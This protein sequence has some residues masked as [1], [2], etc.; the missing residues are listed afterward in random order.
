[1]NEK[2]VFEY[3]TSEENAWKTTRIPLTG[4]KDWNMSEHIE[5]CTNVANAWFHSGKNDGTRPYD[6]IVTPII[7]VAFRTEGFDVKDIVPYVDD[8][9]ESYKSFIIKKLHPQW[10]RRMELDTLIDD[11]VETSVIY[12]LVLMKDVN[13]VRPEVVDLKTIA[14][15]DQ[16][17]VLAGPICLKHQYT[18]AEMVSFKGK[19]DDDKINQAIIQSSEEKTVSTANDQV[20]KTPSKYITVYELRGMMP[21]YWLKEDGEMHDYVNQMHLVC[22]YH[23]ATG[24]KQGITLYKGEDKPLT[25]TFK[26]LKIDRIRSKGRACGRS[27]V[28][29]L[30]E[31]Q[32]WNNYAGIKLKKMLDSAV[33]LVITDSDELAN[34]KLT[35]LKDNTILK[36]NKGDTT[37]RLDGQLQNLPAFQNY[38][39]KQE[40]SARN[41]GS[42]S[43]L[44]LG[45]TPA[46]GTPL[47]TTEIVHTEGVGIHEYRQGKIATFFADVL[48]RD[49]ILGYLVKE[50]NTGV[51]FSE[52]LSLDEMQE[53]ASAIGRNVVE[54]KIKRVILETGKIPT[55]QDREMMTQVFTDEFMKG[56]NRKFFETIKGELK[57]IPVSVMINIKGKQ[58]R[59]AQNADKITNIIRE[60]VRNPQMTQVPGIGKALNELLEESGMSPIDW[61]QITKVQP[62]Q[63]VQ[64]GTFNPKPQAE[65]QEQP[66]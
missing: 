51:K 64:G 39:I 40:N 47:G 48:Y 8:V 50:I 33:N 42:A 45:N 13:S 21:E 17:D 24:N 34:Q 60:V 19:W 3:I 22:Y 58:R 41:I 36:Q 20:A 59:M 32:V 1:M 2:T 31:P 30:F 63:P 15:C 55:D 12:D 37:M 66:A 25:D 27:I 6:D 44:A 62:A 54:D 26:A 49:W 23:D 4:S 16:T 61:G 5:R 38:Q 53:V 57:D 7:N 43:E 65:L 28:E 11:V 29:S 35:E 56:G 52:E 9:N 10:A 18:I 14:F 46:S